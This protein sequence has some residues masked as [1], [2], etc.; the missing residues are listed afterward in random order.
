MG[1]YRHCPAVSRH[2]VWESPAAA[3]GAQLHDGAC[4][5]TVPRPISSISCAFLLLVIGARG[6]WVTGRVLSFVRFLGFWGLLCLL[7]GRLAGCLPSYVVRSTMVVM[8]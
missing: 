8:Q 5:A 1:C 2:W 7:Q 6:G 3:W 4:T